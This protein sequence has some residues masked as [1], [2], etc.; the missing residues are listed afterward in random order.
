MDMGKQGL[1]IRRM[2]VP[3]FVA[4]VFH[5][6][7]A[8]AAPDEI[9]V[10]TDEFEKPGEIG[11]E[12]HVNYAS[13]ARRAPEF[14]G[15]QVPHRVLRV[16]P[17]VVWGLSGKW[18]LGLHFPLSYSR[19]TDTLTLDGGKI[20]LH[21]LDVNAYAPERSV[22]YGVNY[23]ITYYNKRITESRYNGEIR[24]IIGTRQ[25]AWRFSLNPI[26]NRALSDNPEGK[27]WELEVFGQVMREFGHSFAAGIEHYASLGRVRDASFGADSGQITY[28]VTEFKTKNHFDIHLGIGHGWTRGT[29]DKTVFKS[30]IGIPF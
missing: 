23:E 16:M 14:S 24:G 30:L 4:A 2:A 26:L 11:Y 8:M 12:L 5:L 13:R 19:N 20:R 17:E 9:V 22:F 6:P 18:N 3:L 21:Y 7:A 27:H 29:A 28:L 10:F 25:E 1:L 15:E